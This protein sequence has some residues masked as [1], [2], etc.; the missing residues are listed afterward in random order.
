MVLAAMHG[1][2]DNIDE[3]MPLDTNYDLY[4]PDHIARVMLYLVSPQCAFT[5]RF[6]AVRADDVYLFDSW[7]G[8]H[9]AGN[10]GK[11]WSHAGLVKALQQLPQHQTTRTVGP[12]GGHDAP[13]PGD[14]VMA[15]VLDAG[16]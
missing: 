1:Y 13:F 3:I 10:G 14:R 11:A 4:D 15:Q 9:H 8:T 5:G 7:T 2:R 12:M 16:G 6:L